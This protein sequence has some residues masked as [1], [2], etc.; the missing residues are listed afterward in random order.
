MFTAPALPW[1]CCGWPHPL[2]RGHSPPHTACS[3]QGPVAFLSLS[4]SPSPSPRFRGWL[5]LFPA[6]V[7]AVSLQDSV[8]TSVN[9]LSVKLFSS[10]LIQGYQLFL[11]ETRCQ[12]LMEMREPATQREAGRQSHSMDCKLRG[13]PHRWG[14]CL[15]YPGS[16]RSP[17][18]V[19]ARGPCGC[20]FRG[21]H[22]LLK[23]CNLE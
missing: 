23:I 4:L 6:L 9:N 10:C 16:S 8:H 2:A 19:A 14:A 13:Q 17:Q 1:D 22:Q 3:L 15:R 7:T 11:Q 21:V 5:P 20:E 12:A 18:W